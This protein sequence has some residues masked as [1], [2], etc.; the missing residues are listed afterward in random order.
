MFDFIMGTIGVLFGLLLVFMVVMGIY[1]LFVPETEEEKKAWHDRVEAQRT[2]ELWGA[3]APAIICPHC[4]TKGKVWVKAVKRK[5]GISGA[6]VTA[7]L[8]T[9]GTTV[10]VTGLAQKVEQTQAHCENCGST[11][12]F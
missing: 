1:R 12:D 10:L 9:L 3:S 2:K 8:V 7:G 4:Q 11:W 5:K 6:K